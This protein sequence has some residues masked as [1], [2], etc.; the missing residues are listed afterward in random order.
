MNHG[1][2]ATSMAKIAVAAGVSRPALY[3][4]F[5]D[6]DDIILDPI[7]DMYNTTILE[8]GFITVRFLL[9]TYLLGNVESLKQEK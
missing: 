4:Y 7:P 5:S 9:L 3:Q 6:K 8:K 2:A 1:Y